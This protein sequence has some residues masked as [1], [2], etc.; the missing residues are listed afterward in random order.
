MTDIKQKALA[1][2]NDERTKRGFAP[3]GELYASCFTFGE[4]LAAFGGPQ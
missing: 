3:V 2:L 4:A 1:V